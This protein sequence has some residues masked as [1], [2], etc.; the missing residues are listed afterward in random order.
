LISF[1]TTNTSFEFGTTGR[2]WTLV[3]LGFLLS[4]ESQP[5]GLPSTAAY[6]IPVSPS[7]VTTIVTKDERLVLLVLW[8]GAVRWYSSGKSRRENSGFGQDGT[9][10]VTL[11]YG[12]VDADLLFDP[13]SHTTVIQGRKYP[14]AANANVLLI[15]GIGPKGGAPFV[16]AL[17]FD[18]GDANTDLRRGSLAPLFRRSQEL[19]D[20]LRCDAFPNEVKSGD[21]CAEL[22]RDDDGSRHP[23]QPAALCGI[24]AAAH[25]ERIEVRLP[26]DM[27]GA[28]PRLRMSFAAAAFGDQPHGR[29]RHV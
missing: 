28:G 18:P 7:V 11:Q 2:L 3:L 6:S 24:G 23:L 21:L 8:R 25:M 15:D 20:F 5:F 9:I 10:H 4:V 14:V 16:K 22:K 1:M 26:S 13:A 29:R 27:N 19:V 12:D 17:F